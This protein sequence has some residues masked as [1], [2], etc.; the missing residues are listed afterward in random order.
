MISASIRSPG[1]DPAGGTIPV[2]ALI[3]A[4][5]RSS[6]AF[7]VETAGQGCEQLFEQLLAASEKPN[8]GP[9]TFLR[10]LL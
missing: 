8:A 3:D 5:S 1:P 7:A 6:L 9:D 4:R 10:P 2:D